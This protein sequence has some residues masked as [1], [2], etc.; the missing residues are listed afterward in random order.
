[1]KLLPLENYHHHHHHP[2]CRYLVVGLL[3]FFATI[4]KPTKAQEET[5]KSTGLCSGLFPNDAEVMDETCENGA[6]CVLFRVGTDRFTKT[7]DC[8]ALANGTTFFAAPDCSVKRDYAYTL[9]DEGLSVP[10]VSWIESLLAI[11]SWKDDRTRVSSFCTEVPCRSPDGTS[12][13]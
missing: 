11:N 8:E 5:Q 3:A 10:N 6:K 4:L 12:L 7:C 1:M 9:I 2:L 13:G